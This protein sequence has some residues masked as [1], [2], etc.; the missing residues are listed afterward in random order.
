MWSSREL[1]TIALLK[2]KSVSHH[3]LLFIFR[4]TATRKFAM[5]FMIQFSFQPCYSHCAW[6]LVF[7]SQSRDEWNMSSHFINF[8]KTMS[9]S[10]LLNLYSLFLADERQKNKVR[11]TFSSYFFLTL[12]DKSS[13]LISWAFKNPFSI[14]VIFPVMRADRRSFLLHLET[15]WWFL[16]LELWKCNEIAC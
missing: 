2:G 3:Y 13:D 7:N 16:S 4:L 15:M 6:L 1:G 8:V 12:T 14:R 5:N 10:D 9:P 11:Q